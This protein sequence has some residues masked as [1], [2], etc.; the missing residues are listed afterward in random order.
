MF[1]PASDGAIT[2][3]RLERISPVLVQPSEVLKYPNQL[4]PSTSTS[5]DGIPQI[6]YKKCTAVLCKP[7]SIICNVSLLSSEVPSLWKEAKV[8]PIPKI[9]SSSNLYSF[10][11]VSLCP[12]PVNVLEK[13][14]REHIFSRL[15]D[16]RLIPQDQHGFISGAS[17]STQHYV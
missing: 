13:I 10:R 3:T 7:P 17:I 11:P 9:S 4:K 6:F 1:S 5:F 16:R 12:P 2:L 8:T 14:I 15:N